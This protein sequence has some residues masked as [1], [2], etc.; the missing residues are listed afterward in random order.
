MLVKID[1]NKSVNTGTPPVIDILLDER[2]DRPN[3]DVMTFG[4]GAKMNSEQ[5]N[6]TMPKIDAFKLDSKIFISPSP[7]LQGASGVI[8]IKKTNG[9]I[10]RTSRMEEGNLGCKRELISKP[11]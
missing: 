9:T 6:G 2:A 1:I 10:L 7:G 3:A 11:E 5:V 4:S 8:G